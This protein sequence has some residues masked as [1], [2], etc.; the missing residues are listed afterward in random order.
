MIRCPS[1]FDHVIQHYPKMKPR[2]S[3]S[4]AIVNNVALDTGI[5]KLQRKETLT[6]PERVGCTDFCRTDESSPL[7]VAS[8]EQSIVQ[9][10][11]KKCKVV[12]RSRFVDVAFIGPPSNECERYFSSVK[13]VYSDL[14]K[15]LDASTLEMLMF[16]LYN[17]DIW[18]VYTLEALC[19]GALERKVR[20]TRLA[21]GD[22]KGPRADRCKS[23]AGG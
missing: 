13:L 23:D 7:Q 8:P 17:K 12:K 19:G 14:R 11:L 21:G 9:Q 6:T 20:Q 16:L 15:R 1:P 22:R 2:I 18:D 5:V 10:A 4:A 3:A